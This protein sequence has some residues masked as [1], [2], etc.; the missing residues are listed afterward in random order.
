MAKGLKDEGIS[1]DDI[2]NLEMDIQELTD[3]YVKKV[4]V[5]FDE[6]EIEIVTI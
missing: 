4:D 1:E 3:K 2:S 6:K 5:V